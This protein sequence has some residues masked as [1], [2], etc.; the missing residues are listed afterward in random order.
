MS[1]LKPLTGILLLAALYACSGESEKASSEE[2]ASEMT[3]ELIK[4]ME[5]QRDTLSK[6]K[7]DTS[8]TV[9]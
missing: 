2:K 5:S 4:E 7:F 9:Q 1:F 6:A 3:R 8:K